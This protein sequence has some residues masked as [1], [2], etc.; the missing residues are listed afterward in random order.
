MKRPTFVFQILFIFSLLFSLSVYAATP[1]LPPGFKA[2]VLATGLFSPKGITTAKHHA[3]SG[4]FGDDLYVAESGLDRVVRVDKHGAGATPFAHVGNFP[5]GINLYGA[6]FAQYLYVGNAFSG[7]GIDRV[8]TSGVTTDF[9][10]NGFSVAGLD[11]GHGRFGHYLYAGVYAQGDIYKVDSSG[12]ATLFSPNPGTQTRYLKFS[13]GKGFGHYLYYTDIV[14][15]NV[16]RVDHKGNATL[17]AETSANGLEG[18]DFSPGGAFGRYMYV[19]SVTTG[20][21][22]RIDHH[23]NVKLWADGFDGAA[24]I[25]FE[26]NKCGGVTMYMAD[27]HSM[28]Y[29]IYRDKKHHHKHKHHHHKKCYGDKDHDDDDKDH[30]KNKKHDN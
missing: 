12:V 21:I 17:F 4:A 2:D 8:D 16:Y 9:S 1:S 3:K 10:L 19:G 11:F 20:E 6:P 25:I 18:L 30:D 13:H 14:A 29:A 24:D 22:F 28:V 23:G 26:S 5:V 27:G 7:D 15:G